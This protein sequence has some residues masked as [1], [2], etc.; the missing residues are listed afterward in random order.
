MTQLLL[1]EGLKFVPP[2]IV[3]PEA[4]GLPPE[5]DPMAQFVTR[6][7]GGGL[8][9]II[10]GRINGFFQRGI[11]PFYIGPNY[12]DIFFENSGLTPEEYIA[13]MHQT[14]RDQTLLV[15]SPH[16]SYLS[17]NYE[18]DLSK[19]AAILQELALPLIKSI[20]TTNDGKSIVHTDDQFAG[21]IPAYCK[22]RKIPSVH[23]IHNGFTFFIPYDYYTHADLTDGKWGLKQYLFDTHQNSRV[24]DSHA[25]AIKNADIITSVGKEF[26]EEIL[27]GRYSNWDIFANAQNTFNEIMIKA[28]LGQTRTVMNGISPEE[29]PENQ[30]YLVRKFSP[31][32]E[33][34]LEAKN[35]NKV[36][37]QKQLGLKV[38][39]DAILLYWPSR[40]DNTQKGIESLLGSA[41]EILNQNPDVQIAI[42]ADALGDNA[43]YKHQI[44]ELIK[45]AP[46]G[47]IAIKGFN[48]ELSNL[49]YASASAVIGASHYEPFGLFWLQGVCAGAYG[50]GGRNG[51]AVDILREV[52]GNRGNGFLYE[53]TNADGLKYGIN[54]A[55]KHIREISKNPEAHNEHLR[56]MMI[57]GRREFSL[58]KM[59]EGYLQVYEEV[60][61]IYN[62]FTHG[63]SHYITKKAA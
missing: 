26:L 11:I 1:E 60:G 13:K 6:K 55:I 36:E 38:D 56:K 14:P 52:K 44:E 50:I 45:A 33:N 12:K 28:A 61:A 62:L 19:S 43:K 18:G 3:S 23:T 34:I 47:R 9:D 63:Y 4:Y 46:E 2:I 49:G 29:L 37:F 53:H 31:R 21:L 17:K 40:I 39:K 24:L 57:H 16:F 25:T 27:R 42:V 22:S 59:V 58:D 35:E 15:S 54:Q 30:D 8:G 20:N 48:K 51:G 5:L 10:R 41:L 32:T 7:G